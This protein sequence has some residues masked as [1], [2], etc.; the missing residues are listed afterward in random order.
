[1]RPSAGDFGIADAEWFGHEIPIRGI[2]GDQ[3]A[4]LFGQG[5]TAAGS[6]K[7]TY[8][9]GAFLLL[10]TGERR[11]HSA[12]GLLTTVACGPRGEA[13]FALEGS[14]FIAGAAVQW[15]RDG[16][17]ILRNAAETEALARSLPDSG[18]VVFVP[19][20]AG[21][22]AP[23]WEPAA[24]GAVF[25]LTRGTSRRWRSRPARFWAR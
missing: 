2:A 7:N 6:A 14:V 13:V 17:G 5:C 10:N 3:Q 11:I 15:L 19:A 25:G 20:L 22:G 9:T 21:L 24:R 4:A 1:V 12:S 18:G 16:L 8:G 23:H